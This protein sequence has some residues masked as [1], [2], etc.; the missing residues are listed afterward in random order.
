MRKIILLLNKILSKFNL[1][2]KKVFYVGG[3]DAL[4]PPLKKDEE[5]EEAQENR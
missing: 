2:T 5:E 1:F 3:N 4:P